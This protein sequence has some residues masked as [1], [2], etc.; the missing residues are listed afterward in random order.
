MVVLNALNVAAIVAI[1][2]CSFATTPAYALSAHSN[3]FARQARGHEL[4]TLKK[5][6]TALTKRCKAKTPTH[7][8]SAISAA[9]TSSSGS[10][11]GSGSGK[12][13]YGGGGGGSNS[14]NK[15]GLA[16]T[17]GNTDLAT[18][19]TGKV[20]HIYTW[21][22]TIPS[23]AKRLGLIPCP[24]LWGYDQT[25]Q[26]KEL[27]VA[28]Y[29]N[30]VLGMNEPNEPHQSNLTPQQGAQ[31]WQTYIQP[32]K[33]QGYSLISPATSSNPNGLTWMQEF[34]KECHGCTFDG[35]AVHWYDTTSDKFIAYINLWHDTFGLPIWVT[36][37]ACQNFNNGPQCTQQYINEFMGTVTNYM[38]HADWVANYFAFGMMTDLQGVNPDNQLMGFNG[39]PTP[40]GW[41][42]LG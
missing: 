4:I 24:M 15:V 26:F 8:S 5:R 1:F 14:G 2:A 28:G 41:E 18:F 16:W 19:K 35:V 9:K 10:G 37:F 27:V 22:P 34:F 20:S 3:H 40:L 29:A 17:S 6:S 12:P 36:E 33:D 13:S 31:L 11:S 38:D 23:D 42:Y 39:Q 25:S 32:L 30:V 7:S 21:G